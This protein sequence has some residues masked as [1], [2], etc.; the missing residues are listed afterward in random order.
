MRSASF[1]HPSL[2]DHSSAA[3]GCFLSKFMQQAKLSVVLGEIHRVGDVIRSEWRKAVTGD[4]SFIIR[5]RMAAV[6]N[7]AASTPTGTGLIRKM[8]NQRIVDVIPAFADKKGNGC[9]SRCDTDD[10]FEKNGEL[11]CNDGSRHAET[12]ISKTINDLCEGR[13]LFH[14]SFLVGIFIIIKILW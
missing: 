14:R 10:I 11:G 13:Q 4:Q 2:A 6:D 8:S 1:I 5:R 3:F 9:N 7:R 12:N